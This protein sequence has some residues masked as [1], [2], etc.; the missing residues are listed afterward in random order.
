[1]SADRESWTAYAERYGLIRSA[2]VPSDDPKPHKYGARRTAV[3]GRWFASKKEAARFRWLQTLEAAGMWRSQ[4]PI[5][6]TTI[7]HYTADF[8]Y[9]DLTTGE[10]VI[11]DVKSSATTTEAYRLRKR[12]AEAI[13]GIAIREV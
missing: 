3:D 10:I 5:V 11:E 7:G 13:H 8:Q 2:G 12:L 9:V 6:V 1:M 4:V